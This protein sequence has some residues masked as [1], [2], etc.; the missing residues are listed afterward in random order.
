MEKTILVS[1]YIFILFFALGILVTLVIQSELKSF[2][3]KR[4]ME[5]YSIDHYILTYGLKIFAVLI[6]ISFMYY[7]YMQ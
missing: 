7:L 5:Q 6:T 3:E 1:P 2:E 4:K